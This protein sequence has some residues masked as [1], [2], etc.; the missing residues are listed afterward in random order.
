M[1]L[2]VHQF[3]CLDDNYGFLIRDERSGDV[4]CIDTPDPDVILREAQALGWT[5]KWILNTHWHP[6]HAGGNAAI[7]AATDA[8]VIAPVEVTRVSGVDVVVRGGDH[9]RVGDSVL[10]VLDCGGHTL[11]H[12]AFHAREDGL[13]FVGDTLFPMGCGRLFEGT[14]AQMWRSLSSLIVLPPETRVYAAHEYALGNAR[15]AVSVDKDATVMQRAAEV[16]AMRASGI[17]TVPTTIGLE[18][19]TNPFLRLP[20]LLCETEQ[21]EGFAKVRRAKDDFKL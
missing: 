12:V 3:P 16:E 11:E 20:L 19:R 13:L 14:P 8:R 10:E 21:V 15:F 4:A 6:D 7:R 2:R 1:P 9:V 17:P 18:V 5:I